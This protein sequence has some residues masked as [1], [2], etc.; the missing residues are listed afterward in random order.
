MRNKNEYSAHE[1]GFGV[2]HGRGIGPFEICTESRMW[3]REVPIHAILV[4]R[5]DHPRIR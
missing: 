1:V 5:V 2:T 3:G 4:W